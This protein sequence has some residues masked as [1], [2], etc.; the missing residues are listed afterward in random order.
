[1]AKLFPAILYEG[2]FEHFTL[3]HGFPWTPRGLFR[4]S[5]DSS[6]SPRGVYEDSTE[7]P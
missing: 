2:I 3:T 5:V 6:E 1:M 4:V 7:T